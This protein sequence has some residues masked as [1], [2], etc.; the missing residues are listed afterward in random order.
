MEA[1]TRLARASQPLGALKVS[2]PR[3]GMRN[4]ACT[5]LITRSAS[6]LWLLFLLM[7]VVCLNAH[8]QW[9]T[10]QAFRMSRQTRPEV[11]AFEALKRRQPFDSYGC[12]LRNSRF[13]IAM[14][15]TEFQQL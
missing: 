13:G 9:R 3:R 10:T 6:S 12:G 7:G 1:G 11:L 5:W 8:T 15:Q 2:I 4:G 14:N